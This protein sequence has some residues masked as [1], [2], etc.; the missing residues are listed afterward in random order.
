MAVASGNISNIPFDSITAS[1]YTF[2]AVDRIQPLS[3]IQWLPYNSLFFTTTED[4]LKQYQ[5]YINAWYI[6]KDETSTA[7]EDAI[8]MLYLE[9]INEITINYT[10]RDEQRFLK[11]LDKNNPRDL[12][13]AIPFFAKKI[14]DICLYYSKIYKTNTCLNIYYF[15]YLM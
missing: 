6:A 15:L 10:T 2:E 11:N 14:R 12:A 3:F 4:S 9:L 1:T 8:K 13:I 7:Q 5:A